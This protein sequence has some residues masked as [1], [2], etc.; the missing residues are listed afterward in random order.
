MRILAG[1]ILLACA[2]ISQAQVDQTVAEKLCLAA[3]E[4]SAFGVLVDDLIERDQLALSRGEE[5]LS[6]ECGQGQTV[7]SRMVLSRQ[8]ENLEYAVIDM[9]LNLS[10]SQVEL[11]GKTWLLSDAM[12]AL[13]A[14][15]DSETQEFV[16]SYL[17]D[18]ADEEFNPNLMLS[19]K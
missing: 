18:L 11:N 8:A 3:A 17:S 15:A 13:A 19:L 10:S 7:L 1:T 6:L 16:E 5:L 9:G 2:S 4:D 14:A 12:K